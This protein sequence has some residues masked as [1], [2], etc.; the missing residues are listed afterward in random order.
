VSTPR[1][2]LASSSPRRKELLDTVGVEFSCQPADIDESVHAD[3]APNAYVLRMARAKAAVVAARQVD[4]NYCVLAADTSVIID[5]EILGKPADY[6]EAMAFLLRLSGRRHRVITA[7]CLQTEAGVST[8]CVQTVVQFVHLEQ[9]QCDA[10]LATDEPWD[11]AGAYA[12]QGLGGAFVESI[13][14]SYSNVVG[15]PLAQTLQLL[16]EHGVASRFDGPQG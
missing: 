5:E 2:I 15:L 4:A 7:L 3:E 14:G 16:A 10:Y 9:R 8:R 13:E 1:F 12:I 6:S 11:K